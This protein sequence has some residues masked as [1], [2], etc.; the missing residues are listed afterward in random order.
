MMLG[1]P[2]FIE[3]I[4]V[5]AASSYFKKKVINDEELLKKVSQKIKINFILS[6]SVLN[7]WFNKKTG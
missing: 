3:L 2:F 7:E 6:T 1:L 4:V 5:L